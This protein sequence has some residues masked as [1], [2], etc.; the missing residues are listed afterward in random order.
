M[1]LAQIIRHPIKGHGREQLDQVRLD[2]G[3]TMPW[4]RAWAIA[5][6]GSRT[7]GTNWA[8]CVNFSRGAKAPGLMAVSSNLDEQTGRITLTH[9][10][11]DP[12][13]LHPEEDAEALIAWVKPLMPTDRAQSSRVIRV[14]DRGMTDT[15][16]PS[17]SIG[18]LATNTAVSERAGTPLDISRWR[19]NL[20]LD[21]VPAWEEFNWV[22]KSLAIGGTKIRITAPI[23][24][25][26][27]TAA[28]PST[29]KRD[30][31]T[32]GT[33]DS[34]GHQDFGVYGV[35]TETGQITCGDPVTLL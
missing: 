10:D 27:A 11:Q 24:R 32:L 34:W 19:I 4:D 16:Y 18:N 8:S 23:T 28:N 1:Q 7:D 30:V 13:T 3:K 6:E 31:D 20:W 2:A 25:C 29:G 12:I 15:D 14:P 17:I 5:H 26:L 22:G 33:L 9:P 35:V 21:D